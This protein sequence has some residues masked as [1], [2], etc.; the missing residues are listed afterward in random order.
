[1]RL[2]SDVTPTPTGW[3]VRHALLMLLASGVAAWSSRPWIACLVAVLSF[4]QLCLS[5]WARWTSGGVF[6]AANS[7]TAV[8]VGLCV[9][10]ALAV[11][12]LSPLLLGALLLL[13]FALDGLDGFIARRADQESSFGAQF[14]ME[15]DAFFVLILALLA[16]QRDVLGA[17]VLSAG[18]L[19]YAYV[20]CLAA[21]PA[22]R[23]EQPRSRSGRW[24]FSLLVIGLVG[25]WW[26]PQPYASLLA[27]SGTAAVWLSFIR[28][29]WHSYAPA[30]A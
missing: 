29:F 20:L 22:R 21:V 5:C 23:A 13:V 8:R 12:R 14:D 26:L 1:M 3:T 18:W 27:A 16:W 25:V 30:S 4:V 24:A 10:A 28:G 6:G 19:R 15:A 9:V 17:W 2:N 11:E 7:V